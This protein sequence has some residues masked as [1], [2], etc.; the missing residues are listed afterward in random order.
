GSVVSTRTVDDALSELLP[1][2][3]VARTRKYQVPSASSLPCVKLVSATD[4]VPV[5]GSKSASVD[6]STMYGLSAKP[7]PTSLGTSHVQTGVLLLVGVSVDN[8]AGA[9]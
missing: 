5:S 3:S 7:T 1:A 2:L 4:S 6:H 8:P 9:S